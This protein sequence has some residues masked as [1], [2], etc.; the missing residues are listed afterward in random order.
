MMLIVTASR[1]SALQMVEFRCRY[2]DEPEQSWRQRHFVGNA[3]MLLVIMKLHEFVALC[4][5]KYGDPDPKV[6]FDLGEVK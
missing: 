3:D 2:H 6:V 5:D 4:A 1:C